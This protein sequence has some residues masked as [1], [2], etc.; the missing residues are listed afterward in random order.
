MNW[1]G[2]FSVGMRDINVDL[3]PDEEPWVAVG[4]VREASV[5]AVGSEFGPVSGGH[6][7]FHGPLI[8]ARLGLVL[9]DLSNRLTAEQAAEFVPGGKLWYMRNYVSLPNQTGAAA[10]SRAEM[11][12]TMAHLDAVPSSM[13]SDEETDVYLAV[14]YC[15]IGLNVHPNAHTLVLVRGVEKG[16]YRRIGYVSLI[17]D[18]MNPWKETRDFGVFDALEDENEYLSV[19]DRPGY[20]NYRIV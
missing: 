13:M 18:V 12:M 19:G 6:L 11:H 8:K 4:T 9:I 2:K 14:I 17:E 15:R 10:K 5:E 7:V 16:E 20:Y 1:N 3:L